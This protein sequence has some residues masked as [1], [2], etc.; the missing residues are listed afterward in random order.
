MVKPEKFPLS[1]SLY[2]TLKK[3]TCRYHYQNL[4]DS[5][6]SWDIKENIL[7]LVILGHYLPFYPSKNPKIKILKNVITLHM[8]TKNH[9]HMMYGSWFGHFFALLPPPTPTLNWSPKSNF[10]EKKE[11]KMPGDITLLYIHVYYNEDHR[12]MVPEI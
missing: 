7:N 6:K 1:L 8:R 12:Y 5:T 2:S 4:D 9:N 10:W 11:K 3:N